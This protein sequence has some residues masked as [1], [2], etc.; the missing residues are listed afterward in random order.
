MDFWDI[1]HLHKQKI[2][3]I[4]AIVTV[5]YWLHVPEE[6]P[7][8]SDITHKDKCELIIKNSNELHKNIIENCKKLL[9]DEDEIE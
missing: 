9:K 3:A 7:A 2:F 6:E 1:L 5:L 8:E 4:L